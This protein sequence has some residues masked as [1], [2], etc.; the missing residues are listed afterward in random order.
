MKI[1]LANKNEAKQL[2][3]LKKEVWETTYRGIYDDEVIDNYD[4]IKRE[5]KFNNLIESNNQEVYICIIDKKIVGYM[6]LGTPLHEGLDGYDLSI[7]DLGIDKQYRG[8]G[9]GKQFL[10]IAKSKNK[11]LFN[12]CNYYNENA[13]KFYEKMGGKII[14]S[15]M[16]ENKRNCQVYFVYDECKPN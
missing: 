14:K 12:S 9:I 3:Y 1:R 2:S 4:Y 16:E 8:M 7:N 10:N 13:K 11:K 6:V 5:E 15:V